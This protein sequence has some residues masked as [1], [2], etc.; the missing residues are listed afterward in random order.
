M[1]N[2]KKIM[3][4]S[5]LE[6]EKTHSLWEWWQMGQEGKR[7]IYLWFHEGIVDTRFLQLD[8]WYNLKKR[9]IQKMVDIR[10]KSIKEQ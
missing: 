8:Q 5:P 4:K 1:D 9:H 2:W 6:P 10:N 3:I 7:V